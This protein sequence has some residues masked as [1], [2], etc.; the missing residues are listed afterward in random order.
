M[1][2]LGS[3]F[4]RKPCT[5]DSFNSSPRSA[6]SFGF[7]HF[8]LSHLALKVRISRHL[9]I[10][11]HGAVQLLHDHDYKSAH[12]SPF[13]NLRLSDISPTAATRTFLNRTT[14][15]N[16]SKP[17]PLIC[18]RQCRP[19]R[20]VLCHRDHKNNRCNCPDG[21]PCPIYF[22]RFFTPRIPEAEPLPEAR[23]YGH[24]MS[25]HGVSRNVRPPLRTQ[26][27]H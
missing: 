10:A 15:S 17:H 27:P 25:L 2:G 4:L 16:S 21:S 24:N 5:M 20:L 18:G 9:V 13:P 11:Q 8:A 23:I 6:V 1:A 19:S 7:P 12:T 14:T 26:S 3:I 22:A